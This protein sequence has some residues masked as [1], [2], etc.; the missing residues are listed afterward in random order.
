MAPNSIHG[1]CILQSLEGSEGVGGVG[2]YFF[3][4]HE[5]VLDQHCGE[6]YPSGMVDLHSHGG[7]DLHWD[8]MFLIWMRF[9]WVANPKGL[10]CRG[11]LIDLSFDEGDHMWWRI[12]SHYRLQWPKW[13][14]LMCVVIERQ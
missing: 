6:L 2:D 4:L 13:Y 1:R 14:C 3:G 9:I 8:D 5:M 10:I 11:N 12:L 7:V